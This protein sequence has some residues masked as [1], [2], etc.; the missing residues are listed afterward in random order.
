M[1]LSISLLLYPIFLY[2]QRIFPAN[3]LFPLLSRSSSNI[4]KRESKQQIE[5]HCKLI[6]DT[7]S[8][9]LCRIIWMNVSGPFQTARIIVKADGIPTGSNYLYYSQLQPEVSISV[10]HLTLILQLVQSII[11]RIWL[12]ISFHHQCSKSLLQRSN[13]LFLYIQLSTAI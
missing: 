8:R 4:F 10:N 1:K 7:L 3:I 11:L 6:E 2:C 9:S 5:F 13:I 12:H